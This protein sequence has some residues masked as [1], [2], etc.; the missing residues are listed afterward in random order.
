[1]ISTA[2]IKP[3]SM[4]W[5]PISELT[6]LYTQ[7]IMI[8]SPKLIDGDSNPLGIS[9]GFFQDD[10]GEYVGQ[11]GKGAWCYV[12][13]DMCND[14]FQNQYLAEEDV[15]HFLLP[16]GPW[17]PEEAEAIVEELYNAEPPA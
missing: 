7:P 10:A 5:R 9:D 1:M 14:E 17:T 3:S 8:A 15:T 13:F 12:G 16:N 2:A 6:D 4:N 11:P